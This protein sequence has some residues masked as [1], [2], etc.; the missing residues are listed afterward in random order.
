MLYI[1][2]L[3]TCL[4]THPHE[5]T[6]TRPTEPIG[7]RALGCPLRDGEKRFNNICGSSAASPPPPPPIIEHIDMHTATEEGGRGTKTG[8]VAASAAGRCEGI[9]KP[10]GLRITILRT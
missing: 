7:E 6:W 2:E 1:R 5:Q 8:S 10:G 3:I 9:K 4:A